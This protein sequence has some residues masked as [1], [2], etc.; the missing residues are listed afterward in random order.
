MKP[1]LER[2]GFDVVALSPDRP[3]T[4]VKS[5]EVEDL[6]YRLYSDSAMDAV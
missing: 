1:E 4:M 2:L 6:G 5:L 3:E